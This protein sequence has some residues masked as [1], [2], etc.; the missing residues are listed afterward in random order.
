MTP[1]VIELFARFDKRLSHPP[2]TG[3]SRV[4]FPY[5]V[6]NL[7]TMKKVIYLLLLLITTSCITYVKETGKFYPRQKNIKPTHRFGI[8]GINLKNKQ[9]QKRVNR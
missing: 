3:K 4:R 9:Y 6:P 1:N 7:M 5:R 2:F 8:N